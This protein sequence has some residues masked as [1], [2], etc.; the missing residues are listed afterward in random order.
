MASKANLWLAVAI[1]RQLE[2]LRRSYSVT[3][4]RSGLVRNGAVSGHVVIA[5]LDEPISV[6]AAAVDH[7]NDQ[8]RD[9]AIVTPERVP[10]RNTINELSVPGAK[11]IRCDSGRSSKGALLNYAAA[12]LPADEFMLIYDVDSRPV[13]TVAPPSC[14]RSVTQQ[15]SIYR[16]SED[17]PSFWNGVAMRQTRWSIAMEA[18]QW[19]TRSPSSYLVGH[20]IAIKVADL[21]R[22]P[23]NE[24]VH[25]ED[26][27]LAVRLVRSGY[28]IEVDA[29]AD[30][31]EAVVGLDQF[32][33]QNGRW[34]LGAQ[35][36]ARSQISLNLG[37]INA[38]H[39]ARV[40]SLSSWAILPIT[41]AVGLGHATPRTRILYVLTTTALEVASYRRI[42]PIQAES[43][44]PVQNGLPETKMFLGF[45]V[46]P[47]LACYAACRAMWRYG[48]SASIQ[49]GP[50]KATRRDN[51]HLV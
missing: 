51:A 46:Q 30:L 9:V 27:D 1:A 48:L 40:A 3:K 13:E 49:G 7:F 42:R 41:I 31:A 50:T 20:G 11:L 19:L 14:E 34:F 28:Q 25:G 26:M 45:I 37:Q 8:G 17:S 2:L 6:V 23:F 5:V 33:E 39:I 15:I 10:Q 21:R 38:V 43:D 12:R 32:R 35:K 4:Q 18:Y 36:A 29:A 47:F 16:T 44:L 22:F 24:D